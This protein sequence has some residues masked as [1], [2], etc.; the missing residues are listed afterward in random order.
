MSSTPSWRSATLGDIITLRY[1]RGLPKRDRIDGPYPVVGSGGVVGFHCE[2]LVPGPGIIVGRKGSIG[3]VHFERRDFFPI[4]TVFYVEMKGPDQDIKFVYYLLLESNLTTL[5]S[6][7]AVP[8]LNRDVAHR[9]RCRV[10][11]LPIQRKIA[12]ILSA[13]DDLIENN[14][15]RIAILE[16]MARLIYREW[17]VHF[18]S[19]GHEGVRMVDSPL[20]PIPEGWEVGVFT[21]VA[22]VLSG[23][24][25]N[26]K[27]PAY[28]NGPIPFFSP[29]DA[30]SCFYVASTERRITD[31]G[32]QHCSSGLYR[33]DTVFIT[34][35]GTVGTV[36]LSAVDMAMNQSCYALRGRNGISQF[37]VFL[38]IRNCVNQL[39]KRAHGAVFDTIIRDTFHTLQTAVPPRTLIDEFHASIT[40]VFD[41]VLNLLRTSNALRR[42]R[43]LL[44]PRLVSGKIDVSE[45]EI[46]QRMSNG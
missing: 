42:T 36:V 8:G 34:A 27:V 6:D 26:T 30:R 13:Y 32:L 29:R 7:A 3:T 4:D 12:A 20:G 46:C 9:Q 14:L 33:K 41:Q 5:N 22:E 35:R 25:P 44:L 15:R 16:E 2:P 10:P 24:T 38:S 21:N 1:G 23:G 28:W 40:P 37:F 45:M 11:P 17:F 18:R 39:R 43:D 19:P 31:L